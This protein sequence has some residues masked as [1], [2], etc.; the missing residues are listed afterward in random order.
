MIQC[1]ELQ[2]TYLGRKAKNASSQGFL[3]NSSKDIST[4]GEGGSLCNILLAMY[5]Y[6][7]DQGWRR[8]DLGSP[9]RKDANL[10]M[11]VAVEEA[12]VDRSLHYRPCVLIKDNVKGSN[13]EQI[14]ERITAWGG[15]VTTDLDE[16]THIIHPK[17]DGNPDLY[18]RFPIS[19]RFPTAPT[20]GRLPP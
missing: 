19:C 14:K 10:Q 15:K 18:C 12:L 2:E 3:V 1:I 5:K 11:C 8:F 6:K 17:V 9:S 20:T 4:K 13:K 7:T 16:A